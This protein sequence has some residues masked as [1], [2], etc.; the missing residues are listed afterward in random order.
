MTVL[1][2]CK[3]YVKYQGGLLDYNLSWKSYIEYVALK[4]YKPIGI[5]SKI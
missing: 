4:I 3:D 5:I 1:L 2:D